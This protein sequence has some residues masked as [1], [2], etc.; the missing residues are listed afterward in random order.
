MNFSFSAFITGIL[1]AAAGALALKYNYQ[2]VGF[3]G[4]QDWI[5]SKLGAG[6]TYGVYKILSILLAIGGVIYAVG[7]GDA[8]FGWLLSPLN[9]IFTVPGK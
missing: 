1:V 2:L 8:T 5:E 7:L 3:T 6:S 9:G 4:H